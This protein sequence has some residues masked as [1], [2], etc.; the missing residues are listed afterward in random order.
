VPR[1]GRLTPLLQHIL[2]PINIAFHNSKPLKKSAATESDHCGKPVCGVLSSLVKPSFLKM[3]REKLSLMQP[4]GLETN[5]RR[6]LIFY[7]VRINFSG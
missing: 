2:N 7:S 5:A 6:V 4:W 3:K 1:Q